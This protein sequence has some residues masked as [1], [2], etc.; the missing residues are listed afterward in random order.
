MAGAVEVTLF[1]APDCHLCDDA[2]RILEPAAARLGFALRSVDISGDPGSSG[3]TVRAFR[4]SRSTGSASSCT[5]SRRRCWSGAIEGAQA[6]RR[7]GAS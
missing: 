5:T 6:R 4:S 1:G 2:K 3:A 7:E